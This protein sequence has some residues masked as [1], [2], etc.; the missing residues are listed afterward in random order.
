MTIDQCTC[1]GPIF[2]SFGSWKIYLYKDNL[3]RLLPVRYDGKDDNGL[4]FHNAFQQIPFVKIQV[5]SD[6]L[7]LFRAEV[8]EV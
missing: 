3:N 2:R 5:F 7:R 6:N 4:N 1:S 8:M